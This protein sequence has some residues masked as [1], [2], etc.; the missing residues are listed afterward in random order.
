MDWPH[1]VSVIAGLGLPLS[2][3]DHS[4]CLQY[5]HCPQLLNEHHHHPVA[6][7]VL[8]DV[9]ADL[10]H[11]AHELVAEHVPGAH[12]GDVAAHQVQ[13][14]AAGHRQADLEDD[15]VVVEDL[16]LRDVLDP[17]L[18]DPAPGHRLHSTP[19]LAARLVDRL[20][21]H[22]RGSP[23][24]CRAGR[25]PPRAPRPPRSAAWP[26]RSADRRSPCGSLPVNRAGAE[27][28]PEERRVSRTASSVPLPPAAGR[29]RVSMRSPYSASGAGSAVGVDL[30]RLAVDGHR[31][32]PGRRRVGRTGGAASSVRWPSG[33]DGPP[34]RPRAR[35]ATRRCRARRSCPHPRPSGLRGAGELLHD[36]LAERRQVVGRP[37]R[38]DV[39]VGDDLLVDHLRP[40][41]AQVGADARPRGQPAAARDVG[42]DEVPRA[43]ADRGDRLARLDEVPDELPPR[44]VPSAAC[45]GSPSRPAGAAPR[46][47]RPTPR[48]PAGRPRRCRRPRG[49][50]CAPGSRRS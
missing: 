22:R 28:F 8:R 45:P 39:A 50:G 1:S 7:L 46:S 30:R 41:V 33:P 17:D 44:R 26:S 37:A 35:P 31:Q 42:L 20:Q 34:R 32:P 24:A 12:R 6:D 48:R 25:G 15:V 23:S 29:I 11:R 16:R 47:R 19:P 27:P 40:G 5:Q 3:S 21:R 36:A 43:V 38:R 18:V 2:H 13:V 49:R 10:G 4:S 14:R 9:L